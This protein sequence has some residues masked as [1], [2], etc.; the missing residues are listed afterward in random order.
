MPNVCGLHVRPVCA[1]M[2]GLHVRP[3]CACMCG[4]HV[5]L[6]RPAGDR[7]IA[8]ACAAWA[9][10]REYGMATSWACNAGNKYGAVR[11][12]PPPPPYAQHFVDIVWIAV[13]GIIYVGQY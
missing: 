9:A 2:C 5:Y 7:L 13:Y 6:C 3:A 12:P 11:V 8:G 1:C 10:M 4:L